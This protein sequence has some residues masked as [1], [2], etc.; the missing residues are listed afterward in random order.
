MIERINLPHGVL[1]EN[2]Q[3][4]V[5]EIP[6]RLTNVQEEE[7]LSELA[8]EDSLFFMCDRQEL[9]DGNVCLYYKLPKG[10]MPLKSFGKASLKRKQMIAKNILSIKDIQ[11]TQFTTYIHPDN[12]YCNEAG[13]V[14]FVHR[15]IRSL[16]PPEQENGKEFIF[17]IKCLI[18]SIFTGKSFFELLEKKLTDIPIQHLFVKKL[19]KAKSLTE[20]TEIVFSDLVE[21]KKKT[22]VQKTKIDNNVNKQVKHSNSPSGTHIQESQQSKEKV[23][24]SRKLNQKWFIAVGF[25]LIGLFIGGITTYI[26][27]EKSKSISLAASNHNKK[28]LQNQLEKTKQEKEKQEQILSGY[29]HILAGKREEAI[30]VLGAVKNLSEEEKQLLAQ[31]YVEQNTPESLS[32]AASL[33]PELHGTIAL[34]LVNLNSEE[35]KKALIS[36]KSDSPSVQIEQAWIGNEYERVIKIYNQELKEDNRA[37]KLAANSYL[38][39]GKINEA[40]G[41]ATELKDIPL[42]ISVRAQEMENIKKDTNKTQNEIDE[43]VKII[44]NEIE[45]LN[46]ASDEKNK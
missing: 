29:K 6:L 40:F 36:M 17:Q 5:M 44:Q 12:I 10:Y 31:Q 8:K 38:R 13:K 30:Q 1:M 26:V 3:E 22:G 37:K 4:V 43:Q 2:N 14:K 42:Q 25:L 39:E 19:V 21:E 35:A 41:L 15:G 33:I 24:K 18:L 16:L 20:I 7:Q 32:K 45:N 46:K 28:E 27:Q 23:K 9:K 34:K 11:G